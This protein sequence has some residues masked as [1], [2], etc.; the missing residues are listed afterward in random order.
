MPVRPAAQRPRRGALR[1]LRFPRRGDAATR[2]AD[3]HLETVG[4]VR[5][6]EVAAGDLSH[7]DKRKL[8][9]A[10]LLAT[11]PRV[12]LLDEPMAGVSSADVPGLVEVI[13]DLHA[14]GCTVLMVEQHLGVVLGGGGRG[15]VM[16]HGELLA[17]DT[18]D[19]VMADPTVQSA[20]LGV[21][22]GEAA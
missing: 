17:C 7:G 14:T 13:R 8:E 5:R 22:A 3:R 15:P 21:T 12:V 1:V 20:Y 4:L 2:E 9:I 16:H 19:A 10:V 18:P 11:E 6:A